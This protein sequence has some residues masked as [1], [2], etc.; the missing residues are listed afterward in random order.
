VSHQIKKEN[1][2]WKNTAKIHYRSLQGKYSLTYRGKLAEQAHALTNV[3][4][5]TT[6]FRDAVECH[7]GSIGIFQGPLGNSKDIT[8]PHK[9]FWANATA[10]V[11]NAVDKTR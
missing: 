8:H 11:A 10:D 6:T 5:N 9:M 3:K 7:Q 1:G 2:L 4:I